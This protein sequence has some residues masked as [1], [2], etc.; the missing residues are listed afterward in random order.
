MMIYREFMI[1]A[2][3]QIPFINDIFTVAD[4]FTATTDDNE[5]PSI[6]S[7][8]RNLLTH[9][10]EV[11]YKIVKKNQSYYYH[12][13]MDHHVE[14]L[15]WSRDK[16]LNSCES[17]LRQKVKERLYELADEHQ[18]EM[19]AFFLMMK[20]I[21]ASTEVSLRA[22]VKQLEKLCL[23]DIDGENVTQVSSWIRGALIY[24][25]NNQALPSD[26]VYLITQILKTCPSDEFKKFI[27]TI[28]TNHR[29]HISTILVEE[30]LDYAKSEYKSMITIDGTWPSSNQKPGS[31]FQAEE[32]TCYNCG[33]KGHISPNCP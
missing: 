20:E 7:T 1:S 11:L 18:T 29:I 32:Q 33:K 28:Y 31:A 26:T 17:S 12:F 25:K 3:W 22:V 10:N 5:I 15:K 6:T 16:I 2:F 21:M 30:L 24:L 4:E 13:G 27:G 14:N 23:K 8:L 9:Y 19:V